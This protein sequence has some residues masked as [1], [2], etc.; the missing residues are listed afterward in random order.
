VFYERSI[1]IVGAHPDDA[2]LGAGAFIAYA[3][4]NG[5]TA[6]ILTLSSGELAGD[7]L[8][9]EA[10]DRKAATIL[11]ADI[12]FARLPDGEMSQSDIIRAIRLE[13]DRS[14]EPFMVLAHDPDDTHQDHVAVGRASAVGCRGVANLFLYEGPSTIGFDAQCTMLGDDSW[15][16]KMA[17]LATYES[18]A[19]LRKLIEWAECT[20]RYRAW[21]RHAGAHCEAFRVHHADLGSLSGS[22]QP[23][24]VVKTVSGDFSISRIH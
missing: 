17:A 5:I 3:V 20:G 4:R 1:L 7:P 14:R 8:E 16:K 11:G 9:R 12:A 6:K 21:P 10:E 22:F 13:L 2:V 15:A 24:A 18:Q 19:S 23:E